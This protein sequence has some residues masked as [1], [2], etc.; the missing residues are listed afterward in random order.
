MNVSLLFLCLPQGPKAATVPAGALLS[1]ALTVPS[2]CGL[3]A[4]FVWQALKE[5]PQRGAVL[6]S[7]S[8]SACKDQLS[9][10]TCS[11]PLVCPIPTSAVSRL[12]TLKASTRPRSFRKGAEWH[13]APDIPF[14]PK[15]FA[16]FTNPWTY[17]QISE[18]ILNWCLNKELH[19][20]KI[21]KGSG[22]SQPY[23]HW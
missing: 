22:T 10:L 5:L 13:E 23:N 21:H 4:L 12:F 8:R 20:T 18:L 1:A 19:Y 15:D 11:L 7:P 16:Y 6:P 3:P 17:F 9:M 14:I 2:G